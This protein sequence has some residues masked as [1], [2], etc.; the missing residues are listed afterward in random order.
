MWDTCSDSLGH[1]GTPFFTWP[2][3]TICRE[4]SKY[5]YASIK[6][7][8]FILPFSLLQHLALKMLLALRMLDFVLWNSSRSYFKFCP[9]NWVMPKY[10]IGSSTKNVNLQTCIKKYSVLQE[11]LQRKLC[12]RYLSL[13]FNHSNSLYFIYFQ[14]WVM[15]CGYY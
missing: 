14:I 8:C 15:K 6:H 2:C 3:L 12:K 4:Y 10:W 5:L 13:T 9:S 11:I 7:F 1:R